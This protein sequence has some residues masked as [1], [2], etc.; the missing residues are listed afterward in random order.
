[1]SNSD[2]ITKVKR[3]L[4]ARA[5]GRVAVKVTKKGFDG[6][7]DSATRKGTKEWL[8]LMNSILRRVPDNMWPDENQGLFGLNEVISKEF[9]VRFTKAE[10]EGL[11]GCYNIN[12]WPSGYPKFVGVTLLLDRDTDNLELRRANLIFST[13]DHTAWV[14]ETRPG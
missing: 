4:D 7:A 5:I 8:R 12:F 14:V 6:Y 10:K 9:P 11:S 2:A 3:I 13:D 1:M